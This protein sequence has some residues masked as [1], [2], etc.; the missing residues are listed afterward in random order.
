MK[1]KHTTMI[2]WQFYPKSKEIPVHL[3]TVIDQVFK[4][5]FDKIDSV[6]HKYS[7]DM[8]LAVLRKNL[9]TVGFLVEHG[10]RNK[11]K[12]RIPVLFGQNGTV[13]KSFDADGWNKSSKTVIEV[14]AGRGVTNYQFLKDLFQACVMRDVEYLIICVR[15]I[16]LKRDDYSAVINFLNSL[17]ASE[18]LSLPLSGILVIGY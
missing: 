18:R 11:E 14:E 12:I 13:E 16:Y 2:K 3:T 9:E 4:P 15:N 6:R 1:Q 7:S 5:N 8:V 10:K 17:Y